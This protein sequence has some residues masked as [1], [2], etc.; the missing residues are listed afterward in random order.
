MLT[1]TGFFD[2]GAAPALAPGEVTAL[3]LPGGR[4]IALYNVD[5]ELYATDDRCS[6]GN[7]SLA[8][9]DL[10]GHRIICPFHEGAFDIRDGSPA[11]YPCTVAIRSYPVV[12]RAGRIGLVL[13]GIACDQP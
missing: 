1:D 9:G 5:G 3:A 4:R 10:D 8:D 6:H 7:A 2:L 12:E 11:G 13:E